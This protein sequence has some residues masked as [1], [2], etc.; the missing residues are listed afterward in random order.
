MTKAKN[1]T[2]R[3]ARVYKEGSIQCMEV[4]GIPIRD[5]LHNN[6]CKCMWLSET[7]KNAL[8]N[9][10]E[11]PEIIMESVLVFE[12]HY[13]P[14]RKVYDADN[15]DF[16]TFIN[17]TK[18]IFIPEDSLLYTSLYVYGVADKTEKVVLK[19]VPRNNFKIEYSNT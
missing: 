3:E 5:C 8:S 6:R 7:I 4:M 11:Y 18:C 13:D 2:P 19:I 12:V 10:I 17:M 9:V 15:I 1:S 14:E 16:R